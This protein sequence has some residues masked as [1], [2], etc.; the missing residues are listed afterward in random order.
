[1]I[2]FVLTLVILL[3]ASAACPA[4]YS[5]GRVTQR[6]PVIAFFFEHFSEPH[7]H[8]RVN[9]DAPGGYGALGA[10]A[11]WFGVSAG[12]KL[13]DGDFFKRSTAYFL[14][15]SYSFSLFEVTGGIQNVDPVA[16]RDELFLELVG[17]QDWQWRPRFAIYQATNG[18]SSSHL[19]FHVSRVWEGDSGKWLVRP[20]AAVS[21]GNF[22][23][24]RRTWN[25]AEIGAAIAWP[26]RGRLVLAISASAIFEL[27]ALRSTGS[28]SNNQILAGATLQWTF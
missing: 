17:S 18:N 19:E 28:D 20:H 1:M 2:R 22:H 9:Q 27:E 23:S 7:Y 12:A 8:G 24:V 5:D 3:A 11:S 13:R 16:A 15:Y 25:H 4:E 21:Y 6:D 10:N 14:S 26:V